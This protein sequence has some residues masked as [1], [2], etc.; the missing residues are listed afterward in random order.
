M[1]FLILED[2]LFQGYYLISISKKENQSYAIVIVA[3][4]AM[5]NYL[6]KAISP[7]EVV[8]KLTD[9]PFF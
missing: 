1:V 6:M 9:L 5:R 4:R 7:I 8:F 3:R 2:S